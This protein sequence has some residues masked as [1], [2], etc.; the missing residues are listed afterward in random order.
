VPTLYEWR[1][2]LMTG[3]TRERALDDLATEFPRIDDR[4]QGTRAR[5]SYNP[6]IAPR[7]ELMFDGLVK[8]E[9]ATG[10]RR[11]TWNA[12]AGWYV[13][14]ASFAASPGGTA[15]DD[16]WLVTF[17]TN[18]AEQASAAFIIDAASLETVATVH[19]PQRIPLGFHSYWCPASS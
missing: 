12:P 18:V 16:G 9:L 6:R 11:S 17:G 19:L 8:Y 4:V 5:Y 10:A 15:E 7:P 14:E 13:G 2:D 1:L 3:T